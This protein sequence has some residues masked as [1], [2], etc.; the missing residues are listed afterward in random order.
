ML[1]Y[2]VPILA[3]P[4]FCPTLP[5][6]TSN[7]VVTTFARTE[8]HPLTILKALKALANED[9]CKTIV[10]FYQPQLSPTFAWLKK[11]C[12]MP[13]SLMFFTVKNLEPSAYDSFTY[14]HGL[15]NRDSLPIR[16]YKT[17]RGRG[18]TSDNK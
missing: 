10:T 18:T 9:F 13:F 1:E 16:V 6:F 2:P 11:P 3:V 15:A 17:E 14:Q 4:T 12:T 5:K 8:N 7:L